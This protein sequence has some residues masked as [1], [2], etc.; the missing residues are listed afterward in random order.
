MKPRKA[1]KYCP[2]ALSACSH[3]SQQCVMLCQRMSAFVTTMAGKITPAHSPSDMA[4]MLLRSA[5]QFLLFVA[6][7]S[8]LTYVP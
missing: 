8:K 1:L 5:A 4:A 7:K 3:D 6:S 2:H